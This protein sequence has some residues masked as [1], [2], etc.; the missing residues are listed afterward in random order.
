MTFGI[1]YIIYNKINQKKFDES[2]LLLTKNKLEMKKQEYY[3]LMIRTLIG[4]K[5]YESVEKF[6]FDKNIDLMKRD[7][8]TYIKEIYLNNSE[9]SEEIF[10]L[11]LE[12]Y[13]LNYNDIDFMIENNLNILLKLL[14]G[15]Y[16][17]TSLKYNYDEIGNLKLFKFNDVEINKIYN[18][19]SL[20]IF[21][22]CHDNLK[23][24][25]KKKRFNYVLD[26]G[27]IL[28]S[29]KGKYNL[30]SY[31]FLLTMMNNIQNPLLIIHNK[32]L[33]KNKSIK[34]NNII[35][36]LME[37]FINNIF[38]TPYRNNDDYYILLSSLKLKL[39]IISNDNFKDHIFDVDNNILKNYIDRYVLK[40]K[41]KKIESLK[42]YSKCIQVIDNNIYIPTKDDHFYK[43]V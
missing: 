7:Y 25:I 13:Q 1:S 10:K 38:M 21:N 37:K 41:N 19:L 22:N 27:N 4:K 16:L 35:N 40:Y 14:N 20:K 36:I 23:R 11:I 15:Y 32:Y 42:S 30:K 43:V 17:K 29:N 24:K 3:S 2:L 34:I 28:L 26:G 18:K 8:M 33:K 12:K 6:L 31:K 5:Q 9:K 39:P